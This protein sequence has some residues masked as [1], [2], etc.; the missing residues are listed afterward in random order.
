MENTIK[1]FRLVH[2]ISLAA[3]LLLIALV[4]LTSEVNEITAFVI[5]P[6]FLIFI[7]SISIIVEQKLDK[8]SLRKNTVNKPQ[9]CLIK[10]CFHKSCLS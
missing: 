7:F 8:L 1:L 3:F 6:S 2:R 9:T 4:P 5:L 10:K